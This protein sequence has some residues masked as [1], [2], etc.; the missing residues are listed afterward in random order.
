MWHT[1]SRKTSLIQRS[2]A[3]QSSHQ[4]DCGLVGL[5]NMRYMRIS[6]V[7]APMRGQ[8]GYT[9][10]RRDSCLSGV[11]FDRTRTQIESIVRSTEALRSAPKVLDSAST[12]PSPI[13]GRRPR[14]GCLREL[15]REL[16]R[17]GIIRDLGVEVFVHRSY[18][19]K[20]PHRAYR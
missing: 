12:S 6:N 5:L 20:V 17:W 3:S 15:P 13:F 2:A 19:G 10:W 11:L 18:L 1:D 4:W 8:G 9:R 7:S 14:S 16:F